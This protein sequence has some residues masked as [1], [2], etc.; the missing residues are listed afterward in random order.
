[1][2]MDTWWDGY[3]HRLGLGG[4]L[5]RV[6]L[7]PSD[8]YRCVGHMR[9]SSSPWFVTG[10]LLTSAGQGAPVGSGCGVWLAI[11]MGG[12]PTQRVAHGG[13]AADRTTLNRDML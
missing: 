5:T 7:Y 2:C 9:I 13:W 6:G 12:L 3:S 1:M 8:G 4:W 11:A 10:V